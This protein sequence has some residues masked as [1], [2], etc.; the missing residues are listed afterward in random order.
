MKRGRAMMPWLLAGLVLAPATPAYT[1]SPLSDSQP[2]P[3]V[4]DLANEDTW[5]ATVEGGVVRYAVNSNGS[6]D[7][8]DGSEFIAIQHAFRTWSGVSGSS[9]G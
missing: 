9:S 5:L 4:W 3:V 2:G 7:I 6:G 1:P 8:S